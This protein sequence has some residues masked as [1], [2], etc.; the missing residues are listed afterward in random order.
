MTDIE[1]QLDARALARSTRA[2]LD[3]LQMELAKWY[4]VDRVSAEELTS[5][6][7]ASIATEDAYE[8]YKTALAAE[9]SACQATPAP[10][11]PNAAMKTSAERLRL[12]CRGGARLG[13]GIPLAIVW[14]VVGTC[15]VPEK[16]RERF[17]NFALNM[18]CSGGVTDLK[19]ANEYAS[20]GVQHK[21]D[22]QF[23]QMLFNAYMIGHFGP[24][25]REVIDSARNGNNLSASAVAESAAHGIETRDHA[26]ARIATETALEREAT[27]SLGN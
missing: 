12:W 2:C 25:Q 13:A 23:E 5:T 19:R 18:C 26:A 27:A 20:K 8:R 4:Q 14:C 10:L 9:I 24:L 22:Y 3:N 7:P 6:T 15:V 11:R 16:A 17:R 1:N 21:R